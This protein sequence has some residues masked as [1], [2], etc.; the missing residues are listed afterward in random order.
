MLLLIGEELDG[1][2]VA[3]PLEKVHYVRE[4]AGLLF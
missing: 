4:R 2:I 1:T 3:I